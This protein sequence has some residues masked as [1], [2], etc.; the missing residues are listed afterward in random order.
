MAYTPTEWES[1]DIVTAVRMNSLES[2]VGDLDMSYTPN[3]WSDGDILTA[4][5]MN[6]LEQAVASGGGGGGVDVRTLT[7]T[8][9][10]QTETDYDVD[11]ILESFSY[12]IYRIMNGMV[13]S[14]GEGGL[15]DTI[16]ANTTEDI[17]FVRGSGLPYVDL[18]VNPNFA[19]SNIVNL[20]AS[21][22]EYYTEFEVDDLSEDASVTLTIS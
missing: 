17:I 20:V 18:C 15:D 8:V 5:K 6:A 4:D 11:N 13:I 22:D 10:N 12:N 3:V 19:Y 9:N 21:Y 14:S 16:Y 2:A 1:A 7:I